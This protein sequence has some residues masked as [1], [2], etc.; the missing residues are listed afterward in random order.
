VALDRGTSR[1]TAAVMM[2]SV[3]SAP[4]KELLEVVAGVV[5]AQRAQSVPHPAVGQHHLQAEHLLAR[6]AVAKHVH[7]ARVRGQV[8]ADLTTAL[9]REGERKRSARRLRRPSARP[10]ARSPPPP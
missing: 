3:P 6:V 1:R 7:A 4:R 10:P 8:A 5:L 9:R 2:P